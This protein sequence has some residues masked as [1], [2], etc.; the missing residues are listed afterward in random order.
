MNPPKH[1]FHTWL[2]AP[3]RTKLLIA[4]HAACIG[5]ERWTQ[6]LVRYRALVTCTLL[7]L[8]I[9]AFLSGNFALGISA[10]SAFFTY[11]AVEMTEKRLKLEDN[12]VLSGIEPHVFFKKSGLTNRQAYWGITFT[13]KDNKTTE[14]LEI[15]FIGEQGSLIDYV[16]SP[17]DSW[18]QKPNHNL[19][20]TDFFKNGVPNYISDLPNELPE[21]VIAKGCALILRYNGAERV[22]SQVP[23]E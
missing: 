20:T 2:K 12:R 7:V 10:L 5:L 18:H 21:E 23:F 13:F 14:L 19:I 8:V 9:L 3:L 16:S 4:E 6:A 17:C 11:K 1:S 15:E 22:F